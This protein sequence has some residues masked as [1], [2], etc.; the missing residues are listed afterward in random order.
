MRST[1]EVTLI[2]AHPGLHRLYYTDMLIGTLMR[3][4]SQRQFLFGKTEMF[5]SATFNEGQNLERFGTGAQKGDR[6]WVG[7][8][9]E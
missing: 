5:D 4:A 8:G 1:L 7:I 3:G 6:I 9:C 2:Y